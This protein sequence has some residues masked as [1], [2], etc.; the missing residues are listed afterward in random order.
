MKTAITLLAFCA[1]TAD[2]FTSP[3]K[4]F[5]SIQRPRSGPLYET[6]TEND[7]NDEPAMN[8]DNPALPELKGDFDWDAKFSGDADWITENVPGKI[9]LNEIELAQQVTELGKLEEKW[10]KERL[11]QE[12]EESK[13]VGFVSNAELL[14]GRFAM[15]FLATG[16]LTEL[17]TGVSMPGQVEELLRI[18]GFIGFE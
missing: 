15:F 8:P 6:T 7:V 2:A 4:P 16:L 10:R 11:Q 12:Y 9:V 18:G 3:A 1:L 17:W 13:T 5:G 14:N